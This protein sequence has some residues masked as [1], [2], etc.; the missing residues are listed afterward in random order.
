MKRVIGRL[1][2]KGPNL[3]KGIHMEGL[4]V[5]GDPQSFATDYYH[6]GI[7]ELIYVDLVASLYGRSNLL[8]IVTNACQEIFI[9]ITVGGGVRSIEDAVALLRCGA[10]KVAINTAAVHR[11]ELLTE[12]SRELGDQCVV[13]SVEAKR[14]GVDC[15]EVLTDC[16]RERSRMEIREWVKRAEQQGIGEI[17]LTSVDQ[18]G[19]K[20]GFDCELVEVICGACSVPIIASGGFGSVDDLAPL[21][22][23]GPEAVAIGA[24][25]HAKRTS[26]AEIKNECSKLGYQVRQTS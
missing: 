8:E 16:G 10:D 1:D 2:V 11:P 21:L 14:A 6:Q 9:P 23:K 15:W 13:L 17:L 20:N 4:R 5:V 19:T 7:D 25:L 3:I 24:Q 12:I 22:Q 18:D 26:V